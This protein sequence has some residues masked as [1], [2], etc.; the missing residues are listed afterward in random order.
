MKLLSLFF[1]SLFLI[2]CDVV[3]KAAKNNE[4]LSYNLEVNGCKTD[5]HS[6]NS[7]DEYCAGLQ[8]N[9]L[10]NDCAQSARESLFNQ[11]CSGVF[12]PFN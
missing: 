1:I 7:L 5:S 2:S 6:F 9:A 11:K 8:N 12:T 4:G 3:S 10:N